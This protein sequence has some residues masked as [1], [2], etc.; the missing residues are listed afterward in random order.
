MYK[1]DTQTFY[2][3]SQTARYGGVGPRQKKIQNLPPRRTRKQA[4]NPRTKE[5]ETGK[6]KIHWYRKG[7]RRELKKG[8]KKKEKS[9]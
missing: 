1:N 9:R 2:A 8:E 4:E 3:D 5:G 6:K 7:S